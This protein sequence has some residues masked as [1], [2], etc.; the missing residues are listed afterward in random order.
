MWSLTLPQ[1]ATLTATLVAFDTRNPTGQRIRA[2]SGKPFFTLN[3]IR[4]QPK[5]IYTVKVFQNCRPRISRYPGSHQF[6]LDAGLA[7]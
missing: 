2:S 4:S 3:R 5:A 6:D 7:D 1:V